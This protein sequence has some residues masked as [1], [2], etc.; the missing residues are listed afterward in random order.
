[1]AAPALSI[2]PAAT[3]RVGALTGLEQ[4]LR[5]QPQALQT[6][7]T[8]VGLEPEVFGDPER[9]IPVGSYLELLES[10]AAMVPD[11]AFG[12]RLSLSQS[13]FS[14]GRMAEIALQAPDLLGA[15]KAGMDHLALHQE[16]A[17]IGLVL[18]GPHA[19][20]TYSVRNP[21]VV[22]YRQEAELAVAN[23]LR[24]GRAITGKAGLAPLAV[25]FEHPAPRDTTLHRKLFGAPV[26]FSQRYNGLVFPR[27]LLQSPA[28]EW[29]GAARISARRRPDMRLTLVDEVRRYI[30][31][32][33]R[34]GR[35][36]IEECAAGLDL[37]VRTLQ[38]QLAAQDISFYALFD[39][40][41]CELALHYLAQDH[42]SLTEIAALLGYAELSIFS[43]AFRRWTA[44]SPRSYRAR[45]G[46]RQSS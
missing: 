27:Q 42:L 11:G 7:C 35:C 31:A 9:R 13:L 6:L 26:H 17:T 37:G 15:I 34:E 2:A 41:R 16:G 29:A 14:L 22:Q 40:T 28:T 23:L 33:L 24:F 36:S 19:I 45:P 43:R 3:I 12:L 1:M 44:L 46:L 18:D 20:C 39:R 32:N 10:A 38:R 5:H 21:F 25:C 30:V 4:V 8:R